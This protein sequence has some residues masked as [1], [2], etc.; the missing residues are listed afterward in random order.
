MKRSAKVPVALV[1]WCA[2]V[3]TSCAGGGGS[4]T[5]TTA[6]TSTTRPITKADF[7]AQANGLCQT[8]N[9]NVK[10]IPNPGSD[11][12]KTADGLEQVNQFVSETL[13]KLRALASPAGDEATLQAIFAK[14]DTLVVDYTQLAAALRA[15]DSTRAQE[16]KT[17]SSTDQKAANDA[18]NQYGLTVC[19]S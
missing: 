18:S 5:A 10:A 7:I 4:S 1:V 6:T 3:L 9:D 13:A 12:I 15:G 19:G 17:T 16:L 2:M 14:V 8:M 11:P